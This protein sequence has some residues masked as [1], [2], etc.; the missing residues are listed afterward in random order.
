MRM[1]IEIQLAKAE[2]LVP[3]TETELKVLRKQV[4]GFLIN[5][6]LVAP[7][8]QEMLIKLATEFIFQF[9]ENHK[10]IKLIAILINNAAWQPVVASVPFDR[11][12]LLL[13][14][15][16]R[17]SSGCVAEIDELGLLCQFCGGCKL[18][19]YIQKAE[20]LGYHVIVS[21]GTGAVSVLLSSGQIECVMGVACLDSFERSF[22][23]SLKQAIPSIAIPLYNSDCQDSKTDENWLNETLHLISDKKL[24]TKVDIDALKSEVNKWFTSNYLNSLFPVE[25]RSIEIANKWLQAGGKRWRPLIMLALH[26]ELSTENVIS[27]EQL[28]MLAIAIESFHKASLAHDDIADNDAERYGEESLLKKHSLEITLNTGDLLLS[29]GYQLI[30]EAGFAPEQTQKLLLAASTAHRELCLGQGEEL[31]WQQDKKMPSVETVVEIFANKTAP[32][33]EV[34]LKFGAIANNADSK[35]LDIL[36]NYS[37]ALGIAYQIKDDLDDFSPENA[38]N[39]IVGYRPSLVLAI[40]NEKYPEKMLGYLQKLNNGSP[41]IAPEIFRLGE[42]E[43]AI[44]EANDLL[45]KYR[46]KAL[47]ALDELDNVSVKVLL[48]RLLNKIIG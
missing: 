37:Y 16:I 12:V 31:L 15:C 1:D 45:E 7:L 48:Y 25:N 6:E 14:K 19:D 26:N 35:V 44:T 17:N 29:Y 10:Y 18:E 33:F 13:P 47:N 42:A 20:S 28:A 40:L 34:A 23:L 11:R 2:N 9:P 3:Q 46:K 24:L 30:A 36:K 39:D 4:A 22:P 8:H 27:N 21:E 5:I 38:N 41:D 32:A 43:G